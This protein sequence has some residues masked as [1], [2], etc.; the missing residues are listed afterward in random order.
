MSPQGGNEQLGLGPVMGVDGAAGQT[1]F[2]G[3]FGDAGPVVAAVG[4]DL[5]RGVQQ[6]GASLVG[7]NTGL[8]AHSDKVAFS[9]VAYLDRGGVAIYYE[10]HGAGMAIPLLLSHGYSA[11]ADM[12][13]PNVPALSVDRQVITWDMR[14]HGRSDC[15]PDPALYS[16]AL[17]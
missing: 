5:G 17:S 12:W 10:T 16:E 2:R 11:T 15:P 13:N 7:G 9:P 6:C 14:G 3:D 8:A 4:E 1:G